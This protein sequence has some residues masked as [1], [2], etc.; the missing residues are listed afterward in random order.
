MPYDL[1]Q[2]RKHLPT[3]YQCVVIES[4]NEMALHAARWPCGSFENFEEFVRFAY[5]FSCVLQPFIF[6]PSRDDLDGWFHADPSSDERASDLM[7]RVKIS[8]E[9][10][11]IWTARYYP[12][13]SVECLSG[14][15]HGK[16]I[17]VLDGSFPEMVGYDT[18]GFFCVF[19]ADA[20]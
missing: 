3:K 16:I 18:E 20:T 6:D 19:V 5:R 7:K 2:F 12:L 10:A 13:L 11:R 8:N 17:S 15:V 1:S 9:D 14:G 4:E